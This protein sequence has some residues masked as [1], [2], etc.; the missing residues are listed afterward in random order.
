MPLQHSRSRSLSVQQQARSFACCM[1]G[2]CTEETRHG[3]LVAPETNLINMNPYRYPLTSHNTVM[4][5]NPVC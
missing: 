4:Q 2:Q 1:L 5:D 3:D